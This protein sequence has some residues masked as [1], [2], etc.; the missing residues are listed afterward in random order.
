MTRVTRL[1]I[2]FVVAG[3]FFGTGA[4]LP[5]VS[6]Q[7]SED[8]QLRQLYDDDGLFQQL[9]GAAQ[10]MLELKFGK[11]GASPADL[12]VEN[13][14]SVLESS[15][16]IES[17]VEEE[18]GSSYVGNIL[19]NDPNL[20][21]TAQDTQ[22]ETTIV[23]GSGDNVCAGYNDS[24]SFIGGA[25]KFTGF[26]RST[27]GGATWTD[28]GVLPTNAFG[29]AGDPVLAR[30]NLFGTIFFST[31]QFSGS[32]IRVFRS[33]DDCVNFIA[34]VQGAPGKSG[35]QD[36]EWI[37]VD[38]SSGSGSGN[39][40]LV[41]RDFGAGNGIYFFASTDNGATFSPSGGTLIASGAA[42]NVQGAFVTVGPD[43]AVYVFFFDQTT[44]QRIRMRK[45]TD[46]GSTF[47]A[48]VTVATLATTLTNGN[49][50][51]G[52]G[53]R[54]NS[55][56]QAMVSPVNSNQVFVVF[57]DNPAGADRADVFLTGSGDGGLTWAAAVQV[58]DDATTNDQWQPTLAVT[59]NGERLFMS[60]LDRRLDAGNSLI[61]TFGV[62]GSISGGT[63]TFEPNFRITDASFPV[64]IGQDPVVNSLYM[65][66][67]DQ[68][69]AKNDAF[70]VTWGDNRLANPNFAGHT[71]QPD[72]RFA[73]IPTTIDVLLDIKPGAFPNSINT[74]SKGV[75]PVAILSTSTFNATTVDPDSVTFGPGAATEAHGTGHIEDVNGD[76]LPDLVL[77]FGTAQSGLVAGDTEAC[78]DGTTFSGTPIHD[79]DSISTVK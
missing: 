44:P 36:K 74:T 49:L 38:N 63:V 46:F 65:G 22:S 50:G 28:Q 26:S 45:S 47:G 59:P 6:A 75:I 8:E 71:H 56:P 33:N 58:N 69:V 12:P 79:C 64:V 62:I 20:D 25:S 15:V 57:N 18:A 52:G 5:P 68:A 48:P 19:V 55:F 54:T 77:H 11:K 37:A 14:A 27:N 41:A 21:L 3:M 76:S 24:G 32:G 13:T 34:P 70:Y 7:S 31:L 23:L 73:R 60:F 67:Y 2:G 43:H 10:T 72:V 39:V 61:D 16:Q 78:V 42:N 17:Y 1:V 30:S 51:L 66:D 4:S 29:D 53:F 35:M 40:Y 9:S